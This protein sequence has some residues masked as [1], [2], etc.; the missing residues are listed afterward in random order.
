MGVTTGGIMDLSEL[1]TGDTERSPEPTWRS[2]LHP[3]REVRLP[4]AVRPFVVSTTAIYG[5]V[6]GKYDEEYLVR[7][8][9]ETG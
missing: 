5:V 8:R 7:Y 1:R 2:G 9:V 4:K 3:G 6:A